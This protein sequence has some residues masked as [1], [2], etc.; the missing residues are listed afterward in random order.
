MRD[1]DEIY[2]DAVSYTKEVG[3]CSISRI[4][5]QFKVGYNAAARVVER[6]ER[7]GLVSEPDNKGHRTINNN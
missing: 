2:A 1:S 4:Q 5:R 7:E 6:M 3:R